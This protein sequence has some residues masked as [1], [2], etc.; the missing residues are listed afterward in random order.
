MSAT[1][2]ATRLEAFNESI[3]QDLSL[4]IADLRAKI[5][6]KLVAYIGNVT[7]TRAVREWVEGA[8]TP[9]PRAEQRLRLTFQIVTMIERSEGEGIAATW[10]QGMNP[11][12][13]DRS[14]ARVLREDRTE[15]GAVQVLNAATGFIGS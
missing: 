13:G 10:L 9:T 3:R 12:L 8:R 2:E 7:E 5:G 4:I 1:I 15:D 6:A 11:Q 14:P